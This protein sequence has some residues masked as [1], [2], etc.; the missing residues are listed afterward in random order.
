MK[1]KLGTQVSLFYNGQSG[2]PL[3]YIYFG[4]MN[5]DG[6]NSN[7]LIYIPENQSEISLITTSRVTT[8]VDE[9]WAALDAFIEGDPYLSKHRGEYAERNGA[10]L[11]F[12]HNFDLRLLQDVKVNV[13][14]TSNKLQL[15][16]DILNI[17]NLINQSW[18][19]NLFAS[20]QANSL[21]TYESTTAGTPNF[22]YT[23]ASL[24]KDGQRCIRVFRFPFTLENEDRS[25]LYI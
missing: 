19:H 9:Q 3:S 2:Q 8:P 16:L 15:S 25:S 22:T 7:D 1:N 13:G 4:D 23:G 10:R 20:N 17:G 12:M 21:I 14:G 5:N 6:T 24:A 11:P 18:G